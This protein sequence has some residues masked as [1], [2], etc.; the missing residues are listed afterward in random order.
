VDYAAVERQIAQFTAQ[1]ERTS[2]QLVLSGLDVDAPRVL[3]GGKEYVRVERSC[4]T[5]YTMAGPVEVERTLYQDAR[6]HSGPT[7]DTVSFRAGVVEAG[8]LPQTAQAMAH[9]LQQGTSREA[10][11]TA[12]H[13]CRLPYS[14]SSFDRVGHAIGELYVSDNM[15]VEQA[16]IESFEVPKEA[17]GISVSLDR[18]S[19]PM[20]EPNPSP[21]PRQPDQQRCR[22]IVRTFRMAY[23][24]TV[25]LHDRDGEALHTIRY[26]RMPKGDAVGLCEGMASDV[27]E[28]RKKRPD[29]KVGLVA[30]GSEEM[31]NLLDEHLNEQTLGVPVMRS[32]DFWHNVEKLGHAAKALF[33]SRSGTELGR[34]RMML[35]NQST[36]A[37]QILGE[38]RD[39]D[40]EWVRVGDAHPVHEAITYLENHGEQMD[41]AEARRQGRPI[42][43]GPV[44]A[45]GKSLFEVRLKR[46]GARWKE[47]T[48]EHIVQ[49]R[50][51]ALSDRWSEAMELTLA[52][53]RKDVR[54][55]A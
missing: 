15:R 25:T 26:G 1:V 11:A 30:D 35:L 23:C 33:G 44:E 4:A 24:G 31:W 9:L 55:A 43:S 22:E 20:E 17:T 7:V 12:Q 41:Y 51:L 28:L 38:L 53:L 34:W 19:V 5:Y 40:R 48:G 50:A 37:A 18:I 29:L 6:T 14:R 16:L 10:E 36:A 2:H 45:T 8:W 13:L 54:L 52:P 42:G 47:A 49:L 32:V 27:D 46:S 3:I 21:P 39:T